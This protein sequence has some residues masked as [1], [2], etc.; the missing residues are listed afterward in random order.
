L[1][2]RRNR[3]AA[4]VV[5]T[6]L[7][8]SACQDLA[9]PSDPRA[10]AASLPVPAR[11]APEWK[12]DPPY[13][14]FTSELM[15]TNG[16]AYHWTRVALRF[17]KAELAADG[18]T[19][20]VRL[21]VLM[22]GRTTPVAVANCRI[23]KTRA[24]VERLYH[25]F[26]SIFAG[27]AR[28]DPLLFVVP[29]ERRSNL[30][31]RRGQVAVAPAP[32][33]DTAP[34]DWQMPGVTATVPAGEGGATGWTGME[35]GWG[36]AGDYYQGGGSDSYDPGTPTDSPASLANDFDTIPR[37]APNCA[38]PQNRME[39]AFCHSAAPDSTSP[40]HAITKSALG[41]I[42]ARGGACV[43]IADRGEELL[44]D[45]RLRYFDGSDNPAE[46]G[47]AGGFGSVALGVALDADY[48]LRYY[49]STDPIG[50]TFDN[51]LVHEIEHTLGRTHTV[52]PN[53]PGV[54]TTEHARACGG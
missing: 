46:Y 38:A 49:G 45:G 21:R 51:G 44:E 14:C 54:P 53:A 28:L 36:S 37:L 26:E 18:R 3:V 29:V 19:G 31:G 13:V 2:L 25:R 27:H 15:P 6:A 12:V 48:W 50:R 17:P 39:Y 10:G 22:P 16:H 34:G 43:E 11:R 23:P 47:D 1:V 35:W 41:R 7:A 4:A 24:A 42:R 30:T 20:I 40:L 33:F 32:S 5:L 52:D 8:T 9:A